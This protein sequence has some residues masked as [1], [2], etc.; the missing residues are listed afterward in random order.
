MSVSAYGFYAGPKHTGRGTWLE[1]PQAAGFF[2]VT[3]WAIDAEAWRQR[4]G[5][6][7]G[8]DNTN[9]KVIAETFESAGAYV[10]GRRMADGGE[11]PPRS[12]PPVFVV[13]SRRRQPPCCRAPCLMRQG[14][15]EQRRAC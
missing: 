14:R 6:K 7:G 10:M 15:G 11:M 9:S 4:L 1:G 2:R 12:A 8:E 5:F 13:T 3:R